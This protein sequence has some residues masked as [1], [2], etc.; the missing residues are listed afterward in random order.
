M[1]NRRAWL[2]VTAALLLAT[3][4]GTV[5]SSSVEWVTLWGG[6]GSVT[7]NGKPAPPGTAIHIGIGP[8]PQEI[9]NVVRLGEDGSWML[10]FPSHAERVHVYVDGFRVPG[11]PWD[12]SVP[13]VPHEIRLDVGV[14]QQTYVQ[15]LVVHVPSE[16]IT[17]FG[18]PLTRDTTPVCIWRAG[19][20][21]ECRDS[22]NRTLDH[23]WIEPD[24][25]EYTFTVD[26]V[27]I[28]G[29]NVL[30]DPA[31]APF[32][33][34]LN[35]GDDG[36]PRHR[37]FGTTGD[38]VDLR[39]QGG[40]EYVHAVRDD[41]FHTVARVEPDG[42]WSID[43]PVSDTAYWLYASTSWSQDAVSQRSERRSLS[44]SHDS[45]DHQVNLGF[46][47]RPGPLDSYL[48]SGDVLFWLTQRW[49]GKGFI[50]AVSQGQVLDRFDFMSSGRFYLNV[51][52]GAPSVSLWMN[53]LPVSNWTFDAI[54]DVQSDTPCQHSLDLFKYSLRIT[55]FAAFAWR[56]KLAI[57]LPL[58]WF[59]SMDVALFEAGLQLLLLR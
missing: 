14:E 34:S 59:A 32:W 39:C 10:E 42:S 13:G 22:D 53:G 30:A 20:R 9:P 37:F 33:V 48:L 5:S 12:E 35:A 6:P 49:V 25:A 50:E 58:Q 7:I 55:D 40:P 38:I 18:E 43:V 47:V 57:P 8:D 45:E 1:R 36:T 24:G 54:P 23:F 26:G 19:M 29:V 56:H 27:H 31:Q 28:A 17:L 21:H 46:A 41:S 51:P 52:V 44:A 4:I 16:A 11:G 15:F 2:L 3:A